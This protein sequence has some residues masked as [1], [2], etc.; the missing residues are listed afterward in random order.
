MKYF[1]FT[2]VLGQLVTGMQIKNYLNESLSNLDTSVNA[3]AYDPTHKAVYA[4]FHNESQGKG[5]YFRIINGYKEALFIRSGNFK[6]T[7]TLFDENNLYFANLDD[8]KIYK[9]TKQGAGQYDSAEVYCDFSELSTQQV[10]GLA[11]T[12]SGAIFGAT[13]DGILFS[14][15]GTDKPKIILSHLGDLNHFVMDEA[16]DSLFYA[17]DKNVFELSV[18]N[19]Q[20]SFYAPIT[21][22]VPEVQKVVSI[23]PIKNDKILVIGEGSNKIFLYTKLGILVETIDASFFE[24]KHLVFSE[25]DGSKVWVL[26]NNSGSSKLLVDEI[27]L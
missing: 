12:K 9:A 25:K 5:R 21:A 24:L 4:S 7:A 17:Q 13:K 11:L 15:D 19:D 2:L 18:Y 10:A 14:C 27:T 3:P 16:K 22:N 20:A 8:R 23:L 26:G 1:L 6:A